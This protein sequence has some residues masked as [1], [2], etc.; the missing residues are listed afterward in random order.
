MTRFLPRGKPYPIEY[1]EDYVAKRVAHWAKEFGTFI[2]SLKAEPSVKI[3]YAGV[4]NIPEVGL[5]D[6]RYGILT[7]YQGMGYAYEAAQ[8]VLDFTFQTGLFS[9]IYGVAVVDNTASV[10]LLK[11]L[12]LSPVNQKLYDDGNDLV[13]LAISR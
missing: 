9:K 2:V 12:G 4:E 1:I 7:E 8:A 13:T 11:K 3:G 5:C 6:I 10:N